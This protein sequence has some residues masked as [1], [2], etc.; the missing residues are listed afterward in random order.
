V[1]A[2]AVSGC[3]WRCWQIPDCARCGRRKAP[4]GRSVPMEAANGYCTYDCPGYDEEPRSG[5]LWPGE[6]SG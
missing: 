3:N 5:H 2:V 4:R 1:G 6:A